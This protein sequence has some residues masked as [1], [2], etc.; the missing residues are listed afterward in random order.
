MSQRLIQKNTFF[1]THILSFP[2]VKRVGNPSEDR[3]R[4]RT[5]RNDRII[6]H[7]SF[8]PCHFFIF[9]LLLL[10]AACSSEKSSEKGSQTTPPPQ[11]SVAY[12]L[13]ITPVN[14]VR[15]TVLYAVPQGFGLAD[16]T[17][18]WLVNGN[19]VESP[20]PGQFV[21]P[22]IRKNDT[23]QARAT[24]QGQE[25]VSNSVQIMNAPPQ[26][27][28]IKILPEVFRPGD[29]LSV[30]AEGKDIDEDEITFTYDWK[31]NGEPAG[32]GQQIEGEVKRGDTI[33]VTITPSDGES[34]GKAIILK[35][36]IKNM[37]PNILENKTFRFDGKV[38]T[39][40]VPANDPDGDSL[41]YS[42]QS[43]PNGMTINPST[44]LV[45]WNVPAGF[46][47]N[48][49]FKVSV[50]DGQGGVTVKSFSLAIKKR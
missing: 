21:S 23:I 22:E 7:V 13:E 27:T 36:E 28:K 18:E 6:D 10:F 15:N 38:Y 26:V 12:S 32:S 45:Y 19:P 4:F 1:N 2:Q 33:T 30:E 37:P 41:T 49:P 9:L 20:A 11:S 47:G 34:S 31:K 14:P 44:G 46:A 25:I 48:T 16:A 40:Q 3:E 17:I 43:G 39:F 42:L 5:S 35:R 29:T 8:F 24:V 50:S